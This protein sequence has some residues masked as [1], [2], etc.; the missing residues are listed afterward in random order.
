MEP[1]RRLAYHFLTLPHHE[2]VD[3]S[4]RLGLVRDEDEGVRDRDLFGRFFQRASDEHRLA[5]LWAEVE[6]RHPDGKPEPNPFT[7]E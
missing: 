3:I 2:R 1:K 4:V 6:Q 7:L 5:E